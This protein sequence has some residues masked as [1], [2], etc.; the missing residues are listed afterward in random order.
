MIKLGVETQVQFTSVVN[1]CL[2][3]EANGRPWLTHQAC[4]LQVVEKLQAISYITNQNSFVQRY[5]YHGG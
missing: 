1:F 4:P 3:D 5:I 2:K